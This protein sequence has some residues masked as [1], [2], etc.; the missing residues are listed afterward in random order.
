MTGMNGWQGA[1]D[2]ALE[3][4]AQLTAEKAQLKAGLGTALEQK[5]LLDTQL[6]AALSE[7]Q[8]LRSQVRTGSAVFCCTNSDMAHSYATNQSG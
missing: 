1:R 2:A 8:A 7:Q 3:R 6:A 5:V 4:E